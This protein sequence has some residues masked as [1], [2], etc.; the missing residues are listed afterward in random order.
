M[1]LKLLAESLKALLFQI[2]QNYYH[3][4]PPAA[5]SHSIFGWYFSFQTQ[6]HVTV[7]CCGETWQPLPEQRVW[8]LSFRGYLKQQQQ[9]L[10][11]SRLCS[12]P[13]FSSS[14]VSSCAFDCVLHEE[15]EEVVE[16][17]EQPQLLEQRHHHGLL[18]QARRGAAQRDT[19]SGERGTNYCTY[20]PHTR[21]H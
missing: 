13:S 10:H 6:F 18:Q 8:A 11:P 14:P 5:L 9:L 17:R 1:F 4:H 19:H 12:N 2:A 15:E 21:G 3:A 16:S 20:T 7:A